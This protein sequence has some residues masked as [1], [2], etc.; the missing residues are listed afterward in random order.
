MAAA[1]KATQAGTYRI[2]YV[3]T[4]LHLTDTSVLHLLWGVAET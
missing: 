2:E 1:W 4:L 3:S